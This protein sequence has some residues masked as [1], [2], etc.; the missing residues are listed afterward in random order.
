MLFS[1]LR[2]RFFLDVVGMAETLFR[3]VFLN[4]GEVFEVYVKQLYQS[5]IWGFLEVEEFVFGDTSRVIVDPGEERLRTQFS[6]VVRSYIPIQA[7]LR[8]DEVEREG[9]AKIIE[10]KGEKVTQFPQ[11]GV[12]ASRK[13]TKE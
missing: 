1:A 6:G 4:Q 12:P 11:F 7:I 13:P 5:E 8:I 9:V 2:F 10:F 3:V